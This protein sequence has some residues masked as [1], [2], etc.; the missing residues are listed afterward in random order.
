MV[1]NQFTLD[2][3]NDLLEDVIDVEWHLL[4]A[5]LLGQRPDALYHFTGAI[6][7]VYDP[8]NRTA[9]CVQVGSSAVEPAQAG[10][11]VGDDG[12]ERVVHF[13]GGRGRQYALVWYAHGMRQG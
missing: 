12:G 9:R 1:A 11:G 7:V 2:Q 5:G 8:F 4:D 10:L 3:R 13:M 6:P